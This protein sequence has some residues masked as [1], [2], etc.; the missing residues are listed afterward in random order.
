MQGVYRKEAFSR[1]S[2][3]RRAKLRYRAN[4]PGRQGLSGADEESTRRGA[5]PIDTD[6]PTPARLYLWPATPTTR[7][8]A[9]EAV[10]NR[11]GDNPEKP[12]GDEEGAEVGFSRF[13]GEIMLAA[14]LGCLRQS[15]K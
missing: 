5:G 3:S 7:P 4:D 10:S 12:Q 6:G 14:G 15:S 8:L 13:S 1:A 11:P 9:G 2:T